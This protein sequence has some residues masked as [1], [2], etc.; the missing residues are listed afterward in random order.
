MLTTLCAFPTT[1]ALKS[2]GTPFNLHFPARS[3]VREEAKRDKLERTYI[4]LDLW[5]NN[6][7]FSY[8]NSPWIPQFSSSYSTSVKL[9]FRNS[10]PLRVPKVKIKILSSW[11]WLGFFGA[12][13]S[14]VICLRSSCGGPLMVSEHG[15]HKWAYVSIEVGSAR[16]WDSNSGHILSGSR[17][18]L[19]ASSSSFVSCPW[20][21][22]ICPK[23]FSFSKDLHSVFEIPTRTS[24]CLEISRFSQQVLSQTSFR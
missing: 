7:H 8:S 5:I 17:P 16:L 4:L 15:L 22:I 23:S 14:F 11:S 18:L 1:P 13:L 24:K 12:E 20:L 21:S 6:R 19:R 2:K 3:L 10:K 9:N